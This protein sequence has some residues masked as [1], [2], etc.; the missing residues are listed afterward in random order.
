[1]E[2]E[3]KLGWHSGVGATQ[4]DGYHFGEFWHFP[5]MSAGRLSFLQTLGAR[6]VDT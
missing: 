3:K 2:N 1:M 6:G 5:A 4:K